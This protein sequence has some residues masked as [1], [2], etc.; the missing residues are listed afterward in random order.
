MRKP[1]LIANNIRFG[2]LKYLAVAIIFSWFALTARAGNDFQQ[3]F[4][5][6]NQQFDSEKFSEAEVRYNSIVQSGHYSPEVFYNLGNTEF[7][8]KKSGEAILNYERALALSPNL[9]EA[10]A[11]LT[12]VRDLT[13]AKIPPQTWQSRIIA[14]FDVNIYSWIAVI[15]AWIVI[16]A[17]TAILLKLRPDNRVPWFIATCSL[18][19]LG[20]ALFAIYQ[21][22]QDN[23]LAIVTSKSAEAR[24]APADN[25]T[26]AATLPEGSRVW[27]LERRGPWVYCRLP[28][29]DRAW[30]STDSIKRVRLRAS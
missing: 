25:S 3:D 24:F 14:G 21:S 18:V 6:A 10:L 28:D 27:V 29:S 17:I 22:Q 8:L 2:F 15:A 23:E 30:I 12:Y 5:K 4:E 9:P 19:V 1:E 26:L 13:G 11:N 20:Y 16:F 7:R